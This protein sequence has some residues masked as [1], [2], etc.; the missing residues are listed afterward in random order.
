VKLETADSE[1]GRYS[2]KQQVLLVVPGIPQD[3]GSLWCNCTSHSSAIYK[4]AKRKN[5]RI[6]SFRLEK[7]FKVFEFY[8]KTHTA[9][10]TTK[11]CP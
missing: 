6:E 4:N 5:L 10:S 1:P 11:P 9:K 3:Y 2:L 7:T 8:P